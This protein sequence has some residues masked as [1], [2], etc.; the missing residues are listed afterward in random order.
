MVYGSPETVL[1][2]PG[3]YENQFGFERRQLS[4]ARIPSAFM[5]DFNLTPGRDQTS[6]LSAGEGAKWPPDGKG[7]KS[8]LCGPLSVIIISDEPGTLM[9]CFIHDGNAEYAVRTSKLV[10]KARRS[11]CRLVTWALR[12]PRLEFNSI[13]GFF[14]RFLMSFLERKFAGNTVLT[15]FER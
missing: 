10:R 9:Q 15:V 1:T 12:R 14:N 11:G 7:L 8:R 3:H 5:N 6:D 2:G 4:Q 13:F